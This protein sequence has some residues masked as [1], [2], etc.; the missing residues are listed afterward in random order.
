M[1]NLAVGNRTEDRTGSDW[2]SSFEIGVESIVAFP[3][4]DCDALYNVE[5][6]KTPIKDAIAGMHP[7]LEAGKIEI[8]FKQSYLAVCHMIINIATGNEETAEGSFD[9]EVW[10]NMTSVMPDAETAQVFLAAAVNCAAADAP[11]PCTPAEYAQKFYQQTQDASAAPGTDFYTLA[12]IPAFALALPAVLT[13]GTQPLNGP[14]TGPI[15]I[16]KPLVFV[17]DLPVDPVVMCFPTVGT[18]EGAE[19][20]G[21]MAIAL[22]LVG[23]TWGVVIAF[24]IYKAYKAGGCKQMCQNCK[25]DEGED[26]DDDD[27]DEEMGGVGDEDDG[28]EADE[29]EGDDEGD[30]GGAGD[31]PDNE[32]DVNLGQ[33]LN[34]MFTPG[35]DDSLDMKVNPVLMYMMEKEKKEEKLREQAEADD[36]EAETAVAEKKEEGDGGG[37]KKASALKRLGWSLKSEAVVAD[38]A[39]QLKAIEGHIQKSK[40]IEVKKSNFQRATRAGGTS[41]HVIEAV[42]LHWSDYMKAHGDHDAHYDS[43]GRSAELARAQLRQLK[44]KTKVEEE[45]VEEEKGEEGEEGE[46]GEKEE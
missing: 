3:G 32:S 35:I 14:L 19:G 5:G 42:R 7:D 37:E 33:Y 21:G 38:V 6:F 28:D 25:T 26:D 9:Q 10:K 24:L 22:L 39:K 27:D 29:G 1:E 36:G 23:A 2:E 44:L 45:K 11:T 20:A 46:E 34:T 12:E 4:E 13:E 15:S 31:D 8:T 41:L 43:M 16:T 40:G 17:F 18:D 30:D